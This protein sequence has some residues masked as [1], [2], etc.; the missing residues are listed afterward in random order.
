MHGE[1][2]NICILIW[3]PW[4][5]GCCVHVFLVYICINRGPHAPPRNFGPG[6]LSATETDFELFKLKTYRCDC[7]I[8]PGT[9]LQ[10][11]LSEK[12]YNIFGEER[13]L[14][15]K[16]D[17]SVLLWIRTSQIAEEKKNSRREKRHE[18]NRIE[19]EEKVEN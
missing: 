11:F 1:N 7:E 9:A 2:E 3:F 13:M 14:A 5:R 10:L 8:K 6:K 15:S 17:F 19:N 4:A 16:Q 18:Q 12:K